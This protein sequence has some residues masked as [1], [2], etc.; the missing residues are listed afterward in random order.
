[1]GVY[2]KTKIVG[3]KKGKKGKHLIFNPL[4]ELK[5]PKYSPKSISQ[6][7]N[8]RENI[9][10]SLNVLKGKGD[11]AREDIIS[12]NAGT[13]LHLAGI[14][15]GLEEGYKASKD[16]LKKG[17]PYEKLVEFIEATRGDIGNLKKFR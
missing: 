16:A 1:M 2:G 10:L 17:L 14:T 6:G 12:I 11:K 13:I 8:I 4:K 3:I 7:R 15:Y 9:K 5:L